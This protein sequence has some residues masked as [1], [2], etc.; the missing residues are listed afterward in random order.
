M[1]LSV[2]DTISID[3]KYYFGALENLKYCIDTC[4]KYRSD[5]QKRGPVTAEELETYLPP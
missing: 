5:C 2:S 4:T 1:G 3:T